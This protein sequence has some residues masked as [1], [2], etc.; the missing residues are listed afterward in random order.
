[1]KRQNILFLVCASFIFFPVLINLAY[2]GTATVYGKVTESDG[3]TPLPS[4]P[5]VIKVTGLTS[6]D[7]PWTSK[8]VYTDSYGNYK[9]VISFPDIVEIKFL[10][11]V[12]TTN[13]T[14]F[15]K[16]S[17]WLGFYDYPPQNNG[18]YKLNIKLYSYPYA[19]VIQGTIKDDETG[20]V[21]SNYDVAVTISGQPG[22][23]LFEAD[24]GGFY[25]GLVNLN[26]PSATITVRAPG[27]GEEVQYGIKTITTAVSSQKAYGISFFLVRDKNAAYIYGT[28]TNASTGQPIPFAQV[29]ISDSSGWPLGKSVTDFLG[30]YRRYVSGGASYKLFT[31]G[32][33]TAVDK[34]SPYYSQ[35]K[36]IDV[37]SGKA[38][39]LDFEMIPK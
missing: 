14:P 15:K 25:K 8:T 11:E 27:A 17:N 37:G 5:V 18:S 7:F 23:Y 24:S 28:V 13:A 38:S 34:R 19:T 21:L 2:A 22:T 39:R 35:I 32:A 33:H 30:R 29:S 26:S 16:N 12:I 9:T 20:V 10:A 36:Y 1:M 31:T 3:V 4:A 6:A